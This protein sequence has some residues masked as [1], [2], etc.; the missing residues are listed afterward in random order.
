M[1]V[2]DETTDAAVLQARRSTTRRRKGINIDPAPNLDPKREFNRL[3]IHQDQIHFG[4]WNSTGLD[5]ILH[6]TPVSHS[7]SNRLMKPLIRLQEIVETII[8]RD[9]YGNP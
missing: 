5:N 1:T 7:A 9:Q 8:E 3:L 2:S 6:S 4:V